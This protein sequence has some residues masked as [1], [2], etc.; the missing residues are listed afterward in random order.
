LQANGKSKRE[1]DL[2]FSQQGGGKANPVT[3]ILAS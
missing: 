2:F 3:L 1:D